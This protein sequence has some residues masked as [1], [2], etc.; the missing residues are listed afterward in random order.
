MQIQMRFNFS[1]EEE[2][3]VFKNFHLSSHAYNYVRI[4]QKEFHIFP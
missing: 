4:F 1:L 2:G 3:C